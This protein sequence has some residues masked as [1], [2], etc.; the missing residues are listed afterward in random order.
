MSN[1]TISVLVVTRNE[2]NYIKELLTKLINQT[3]NR[4]QYEI[5]IVDGQSEDKTLEVIEPILK[6][7]KDFIRVIS[8][9]QK[10]LPPGWNLGIKASRGDYI[11]RV[12]GHT[13]V[14]DDFLENYIH[15]INRKPEVDCVGGIIVSKGEG[16]QGEINQYVYSHR[17]GVGNSKF[18]TTKD[19]WEGF[20]DTVP[21][22]AY[23]KEVFETV[24][25]FNEHLK[26]NEDIE[27]HK[28]MKDKG[29]QFYLSTSI[30]STYYVRPSLSGLIKKSLGDGVWNIMANRVSPGSLRRRHKAPLYAF[31]FG[32]LVT[33]AAI[34]HPVARW[35]FMSMILLYLFAAAL[36]TIE[37]AKKNGIKYFVPG[38]FTFFC[39]HFFRGFGSFSAH[40][41]KEY[42]VIN[43]KSQQE[44]DKRFN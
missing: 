14:P 12:D 36:S 8:N 42:W 23:K 18:R 20:V 10:T 33:I 43:Q 2:E 21:Y 24:G 17:F 13:L 38:I 32:V 1:V 16:F 44:S 25:Y 22:G 19:V 7:N 15:L 29:G 37:L 9:P 26:R 6:K 34:L 30:Q 41:K 35:C 5:I 28:R 40:F 11:L 31:S 3:L 39:L 27:F 4:N